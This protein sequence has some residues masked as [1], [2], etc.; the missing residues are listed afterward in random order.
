MN[1]KSILS[2]LFRVAAAIILL[3]TLYFKFT[4]HPESVELFTKLGVEPWGR[5]GTGIIE[6]ITGVLLLIP[7]TAFVG[8]FLGMGLM[9]GAILSHLTVIGIESKGDGG[10]LFT[11]AIIVLVL[12]LL[13]QFLHKEQGITL[14]KRF[15]N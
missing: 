13:I 2:W 11:L 10:Q 5:V 4:A 8:G 6:L 1:L 9:A 7:A 14:F 12:S 15:F 3:Q